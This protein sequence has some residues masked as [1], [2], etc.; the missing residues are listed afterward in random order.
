M[1]SY[2]SL[3]AFTLNPCHGTGVLKRYS[4][5]IFLA[6][7]NRWNIF[8]AVNGLAWGLCRFTPNQV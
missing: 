7:Q 5:H 1:L 3:L 8:N 6:S 4:M 2:Q